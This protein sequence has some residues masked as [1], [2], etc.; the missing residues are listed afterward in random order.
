MARIHVEGISKKFNIYPSPMDRLKDLLWMRS[1]KTV[2]TALDNISFDVLDGEAFA[3]IGQNGSGKSTL[4]QIIAGVQQ[5]TSG[6]VSVNGRVAALLELGAGFNPE[7]SGR[8][9]VYLNG[10]LMGI[11]RSEME[12]RMPLI[13]SFA[14]IGDFINKPVKT[15]SSGMYIRLAFASAIN[16]DPDILIVDE[17]LAVG[18]SYFQLKCIAK[19]KQFRQ[20]GKTI[21]YVTHDTQSVK[22]ICDR[23]IW[24]DH[25]S[26]MSIGQSTEVVNRYEDFMRQKTSKSVANNSMD[27]SHEEKSMR[28]KH[29]NYKAGVISIVELNDAP[30]TSDAPMVIDYL[31]T[32]RLNIEFELYIDID[33]VVV[34]LA[35][36]DAEDMY[37]CG[38]NTKLDQFSVP[39][40]KGVHSVELLLPKLRLCPGTYRV[41][42]GIF[43]ENGVVNIDYLKRCVSILV[44]NSVYLGEGTVILEHTWKCGG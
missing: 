39:G 29:D 38:L 31:D 14:E 10:S 41:D 35:I 3:I 25:G 9:N 24:I 20:Q 5:S 16:V 40:T 4:L 30:I 23:A 28:A 44:I 1:K 6:I 27:L 7:F 12:E 8:D 22:N 34:G 36:F 17:A 43:E 37:V 26:Q 15:Y 19:I 2:Y 21:L 33:N 18:D 11:S 42:V 13:E 32:I